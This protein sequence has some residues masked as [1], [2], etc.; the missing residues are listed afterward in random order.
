MPNEEEVAIRHKD[1]SEVIIDGTS[2]PVQITTEV[3]TDG[4]NH[5]V[6]TFQDSRF[7]RTWNSSYISINQKDFV[8]T[9]NSVYFETN[10]PFVAAE[11][12]YTLVLKDTAGLS[13]SDRKSVV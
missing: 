8:H 11:K 2:Y 5:A 10:E 3:G 4:L 9:R 1:I 7:S 6:Y 12:E 13:S